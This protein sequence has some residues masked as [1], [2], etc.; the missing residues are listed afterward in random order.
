[1]RKSGNGFS[2]LLALLT[3]ILSTLSIGCND[4]DK[5]TVNALKDCNIIHEQEFGGVYIKST[6]DD[7]NALGFN[8]GDSVNIT[9]SNGYELK[10][11]PY[12]NGYY[13]KTGESLLIA[14]PGYEYI[15]AA[16]NNGDDLWDVA[17][18]LGSTNAERHFLWTAANLENSMT[19]TI[20]LAEQGKYT[21]IQQARDIHYFDDRTLYASD[22]V[23]A[24]FRSLKGGKLKENLLFRSASPCDDQHKRAKFVDTLMKK[25]GI[26]YVIDLADTDTKIQGYIATEGFNSGYFKTLYDT[27]KV[28]ALALNMNFN[29]EYFKGQVVKALAA[30]SANDGPFLIH[31]TEG[32]DRT[33]FVCLFIEA[34]A[35]AT[36]TEIVED[37]MMTYFN[38]YAITKAFDAKRYDTI[39]SNVLDPMLE[40]IVDAENVDI[41]TEGLA[42]Y[43]ERFLFANGMTDAE[44]TALKTKICVV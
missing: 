44:I 16:I 18:L 15:K 41:K 24:N 11:I 13:T 38:Y 12:Y 17:G 23:F 14:Y 35:G 30:I 42:V 29:S 43:A 36:Y 5:A 39:V 2:V 27:D 25:A 21:D 26:E 20:T 7:F 33:G 1:M 10:D 4:P 19:A 22:E 31:C 6:I 34:L 32:K 3:A 37:Y 8:Y 40:T 9:F 28:A